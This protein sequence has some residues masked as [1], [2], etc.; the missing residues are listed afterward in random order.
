VNGSRSLPFV[1]H[2]DIS[3]PHVIVVDKSGRRFVNE[4]QSYM[5]VGQKLYEHRQGVRADD[6]FA[7]AIIESRHRKRY[8]WG[9]MPPA[10]TPRSWITS[11]YMKKA[12]TIEQLAAMC[13]I[14]PAGLRETVERFNGFCTD[15]VDQDFGRGNRAFDRY[16]GDPT[17]TPNP[18]LG[19]IDQPPY[20]AVALYPG[21]V[22]TCGGV[23]C[24]EHS[25]VLTEDGSVITGLY[26]TGNS[27]A[28][29]FGRTYVGAGASIGAAFVFGYRAA[30]HATGTTHISGAAEP[31]TSSTR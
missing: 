14:D 9:A 23:I 6:P 1:H 30:L 11:G 21:D 28:S 5:E 19:A 22:G 13:E 10:L 31:A 18:A 29:V 3:L 25:R 24:D 17:V 26:A 27:T 4:S 8:F 20:Y 2:F 15:G 12:R 7:W 16:H